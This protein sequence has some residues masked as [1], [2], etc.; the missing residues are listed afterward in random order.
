MRVFDAS[1]RHSGRNSGSL[2]PRHP[3]HLS[4]LHA[5]DCGAGLRS[6]VGSWDPG[7]RDPVST[8]TA[9]APLFRSCV[10]GGRSV[11]GSRRHASTSR[12]S[13]LDHDRFGHWRGHRRHLPPHS[14]GTRCSDESR[15][16]ARCGGS[17]PGR[18]DSLGRRASEHRAPW[19]DKMAG[20][21]DA[22]GESIRRRRVS[23]VVDPTPA[24]PAWVNPLKS[25]QQ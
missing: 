23:I 18:R 11:G 10:C 14:D 9:Q 16:R 13:T 22:M 7:V 19:S 17:A 24:Q 12:R 25:W 8:E 2:A 20:G 3:L 4:R 1:P 15:L 5:M 6:R 21:G